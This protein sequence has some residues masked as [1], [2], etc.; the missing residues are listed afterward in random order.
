MTSIFSFVAGSST[1]SRSFGSWLAEA[2]VD[3]ADGICRDGPAFQASAVDPLLDRD[4]R[5]GL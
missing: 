3:F 5:F 2:L 1:Q 4:V